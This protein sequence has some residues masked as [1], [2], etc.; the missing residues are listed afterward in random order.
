MSDIR[1]IAEGLTYENILR[2]GSPC[3]RFEMNEGTVLKLPQYTQAEENARSRILRQICSR[4]DGKGANIYS[5]TTEV[6][7]LADSTYEPEDIDTVV[8]PAIS[9][10]LADDPERYHPRGIYGAP[11]LVVEFVSEG[12]AIYTLMDKL[13]L[14]SLVG[15]PELWVFCVEEKRVVKYAREPGAGW[16]RYIY[17]YKP[18]DAF[19]SESLPSVHLDLEEIFDGL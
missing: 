9:V 17:T 19:V 12:T 1:V 3:P 18:E 15:V 11:D 14:Y 2:D 8:Q 4:L 10:L 7:L 5:C 16:L 13:H 6:L